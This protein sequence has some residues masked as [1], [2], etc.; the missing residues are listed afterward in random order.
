MKMMR[1]SAVN[2]SCTNPINPTHLHEESLFF[3]EVRSLI[4]EAN[5]GANMEAKTCNTSQTVATQASSCY[6]RDHLQS[7]TDLGLL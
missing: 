1:D 4:Q 3:K 2:S 6:S 7:T 5:S